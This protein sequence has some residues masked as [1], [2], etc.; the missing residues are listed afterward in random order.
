MARRSKFE[1][2]FRAEYPNARL[3]VEPISGSIRRY[4]VYAG[5]YLCAQSVGRHHTFMVA[6][7][8]AH[9]GTITPDPNEVATTD[10][11]PA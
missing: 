7:M 1:K 4:T 5:D 11:H 9:R 10:G 3:V 2:M 6:Y 8:D